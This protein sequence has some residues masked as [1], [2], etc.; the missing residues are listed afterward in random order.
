[1]A[2]WESLGPPCERIF[3]F[4]R[5]SGNIIVSCCYWL[6]DIQFFERRFDCANGCWQFAGC[7]QCPDRLDPRWLFPCSILVDDGSGECEGRLGA[8]AIDAGL[9]TYVAAHIG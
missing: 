2:Y 9:N 4:V 7:W 8:G 1:M 6:Y 3:P 5:F